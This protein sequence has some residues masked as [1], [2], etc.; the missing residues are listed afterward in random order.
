MTRVVTLR[1]D[2]A[3]PT[4]APAGG[5]ARRAALEGLGTAFLLAT[6]VG[7]GVMGERL[8]GGSPALALLANSIATG[9]GLVAIIL[10]FGSVS[11][12]HLNPIVTLTQAGRGALS[13]ADVPAYLAAQA[14]GALA[15]VAAAH[16]MFGMPIFS[17]ATR[18]R[19]GP[20]QVFAELVATLGLVLVVLGTSH[21]GPP[22]SAAAVGCYIAAAYWFT[23]STA[24][25]NPAVTLG[26]A[27]SDTFV[28]IRPR[29]VPGFL[30]GQA[31]GGAA[32]FVLGKWLMPRSP[33]PRK[34]EPHETESA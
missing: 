21:L 2:R 34:G 20:S 8:S 18:S 14:A 16:A 3:V 26:R 11:G 13:R 1:S 28:G 29:D 9:A 7:S 31:A 17:I 10:T 24:F 27:L 6:I 30:A 4:A 5:L 12:A 22:A 19:A 32:A 25:A 23:S 15:G 33:F